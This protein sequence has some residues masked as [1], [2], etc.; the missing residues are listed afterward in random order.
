[1]GDD[2][3]EERPELA[4]NAEW[5]AEMVAA[6]ERK[7][8]TQAEL[9]RLVGASQP[10]ITDIEKGNVGAS[11]F[12]LPICR[13]LKIAPPSHLLSPEQRRWSNIGHR[14][15]DEAPARFIATMETLEAFLKS[16]R[17]LDNAVADAVPKRRRRARPI[18]TAKIVQ[19]VSPADESPADRVKP[20]KPHR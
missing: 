16:L 20:R 2:T 18:A 14:L 8:M 13:L 9:A 4:T 11:S 1:M 7:N 15:Q 3:A 6:R 5:R 19:S 12:V 17:E 10:N